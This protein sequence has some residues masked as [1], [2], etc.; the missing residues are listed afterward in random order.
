[1]TRPAADLIA[2]SVTT[3]WDNEDV[4]DTASSALVGR[5]SELGRMRRLLSDAEAGQPVVLLVSG[6]AG[7]GKTRLILELAAEAAGRGFM[8]LSGR[9]A[10]L[11]ETIPYLPLADAL[12]GAGTGRLAEAVAAR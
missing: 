11:A 5:A 10:E 12:R 2:R 3:S 7:V 6:D 9:C 8:T 1:M 4:I